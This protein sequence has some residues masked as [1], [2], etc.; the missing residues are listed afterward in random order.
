MLVG[1]SSVCLEPRSP[2]SPRSGRSLNPP[3][4]LI[5]LKTN[6]EANS[7]LKV[8]KLV[9]TVTYGLS[10]PFE[11]FRG[12][13]WPPRP[14]ST[15]MVIGTP[16]I[17]LIMVEPIVRFSLGGQRRSAY[18]P[19]YWSLA[20][21]ASSWLSKVTK[22]SPSDLPEASYLICTVVSF[23]TVLNN[24]YD[25]HNNNGEHNKGAKNGHE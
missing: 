10:D 17:A 16:S 21:L 11:S 20:L 25:G 9:F 12:G 6:G 2:R 22:A 13:L 7:E 14:A 18:F 8:S 15:S 19:S 5:T 4:L 3:R 23:P 24:S 1:S